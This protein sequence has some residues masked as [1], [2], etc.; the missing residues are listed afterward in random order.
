MTLPLVRSTSK[1]GGIYDWMEQA[2][3]SCM[4]GEHPMVF[5]RADGK[6]WL[7]VMSAEEALKLIGNEL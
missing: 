7:V 5:C 1:I 2:E 3:A 4:S 6:K